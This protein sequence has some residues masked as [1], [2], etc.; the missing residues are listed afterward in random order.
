MIKRVAFIS[1]VCFFVYCYSASAQQRGITTYLKNSG[2]LANEPD[3]ADF[4]RIIS[5]TADSSGLFDIN[6]YYPNKQLKFSGK[7]SA[8]EAIKLQSGGTYYSPKG[9][10]REMAN[11]KDGKLDGDNY[12]YYPNGHLYTHRKFVP[13]DNNSISVFGGRSLVIENRDSTGKVL[14][15]NGNGYYVGYDTDFTYISEEGPIKD[16]FRDGTWKGHGGGKNTDVR[17]SFNQGALIAGRMV[18]ANNQS[19]EYTKREVM[20]EFFGGLSEFGKFLGENIKYPKRALN[21]RIS[22]AVVLAFVVERDGSLSNFVVKSSPDPELSAE[23][24]RVLMRSPRWVPGKQYGRP[25][26]V[27]YTI[28]VRFAL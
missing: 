15:E 17:E 25:V 23:A 19:F 28:P 7:T 6:E 24:L 5:E 13:G 9:I 3:S 8:K 14:T 26:R 16:G 1:I 22:G 10:K 12:L 4:I 2:A 27:T 20:P 18:D 11:Y 21:N